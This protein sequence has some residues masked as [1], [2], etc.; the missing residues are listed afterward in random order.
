M[1]TF[2]EVF[3]WIWIIGGILLL[4][5]N[6]L[7]CGF[8]IC[9]K[10]QLN[11]DRWFGIVKGIWVLQIVWNLVFF[12]ISLCGSTAIEAGKSKVTYTLT[13]ETDRTD[14]E[15]TWKYHFYRPGSPATEISDEAEDATPFQKAY[16][17]TNFQ[18]DGLPSKGLIRCRFPDG[19]IAPSDDHDRLG[20]IIAFNN[21][22][23]EEAR[24]Y[25]DLVNTPHPTSFFFSGIF[26]MIIVSVIA[27]FL[28][29]FAEA[30]VLSAILLIISNPLLAAAVY[31]PTIYRL[32]RVGAFRV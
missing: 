15:Q 7:F 18:S 8:L 24:T 12:S 26:P 27:P 31:G 25:I 1:R 9:T 10:C 20:K 17:D 30:L 22:S 19:S 23:E 5:F 14:G 29:T 16:N 2:F 6:S 11:M 21:L 4:P 3:T 28:Y 13:Q 32:F